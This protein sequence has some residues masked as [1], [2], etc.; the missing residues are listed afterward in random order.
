MKT[1][2]VKILSIIQNGETTNTNI[3]QKMPF[4]LLPNGL[5]QCTGN[6]K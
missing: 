2:K 5:P 6:I 3:A 1:T 4:L